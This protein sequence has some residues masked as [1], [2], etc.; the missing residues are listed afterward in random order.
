MSLSYV[1]IKFKQF[2]AKEFLK[3]FMPINLL[4]TIAS[5][6]TLSKIVVF[7]ATTLGTIT[8]FAILL[9]LL[10]RKLENAGALTPATHLF[11]RVRDIFVV[12]VS[13]VSA[14]IAFTILKNIFAIP[15]PFVTDPSIH[16]LFSETGYAFPSGH[17]TIYAALAASLF[18]INRRAGVLAGIAALII[19]IARVLAGVHYPLDIIGGYCLG[20]LVAIVV[21]RIG[22][23]TRISSRG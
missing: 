17:A 10:F 1:L 11:R 3:L 5:N 19:G 20:I 18:L 8:V 22:K 2:L 15:R 23:W 12:G 4:T 21:D 14:G 16:A 6:P 9:F 7:C 13:V